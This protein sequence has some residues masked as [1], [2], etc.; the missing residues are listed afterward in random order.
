MR[1]SVRE[2]ESA[3]HVDSDLMPF[4]IVYVVAFCVVSAVKRRKS[5]ASAERRVRSPCL[6]VLLASEACVGSDTCV[7]NRRHRERACCKNLVF[8]VC[9][10]EGARPPA[11]GLR[12]ALLDKGEIGMTLA[13]VSTL[14]P[15]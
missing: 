10:R 9:V 14:Q 6:R 11:H 2:A 7:Y 15:R 8:A 3:G 12:L 4:G 13:L 5:A 1:E